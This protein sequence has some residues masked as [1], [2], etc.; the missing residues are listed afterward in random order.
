MVFRGSSIP[1]VLWR[2]GDFRWESVTIFKCSG[3]LVHWQLRSRVIEESLWC[4]VI[5]VLF[6]DLI[7][8][9]VLNHV[10]ICLRQGSAED[11]FSYQ[12]VPRLTCSQ[13][14]LAINGR[15]GDD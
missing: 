13:S 12:T 1:R 8:L 9:V 11:G 2:Y 6:L 5:I 14:L 4:R 7:Q 10:L 15:L 3:K